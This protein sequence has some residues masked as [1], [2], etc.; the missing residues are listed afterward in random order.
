[1]MNCAV[2]C[3]WRE[4]QLTLKI[5]LCQKVTALFVFYFQLS[6]NASDADGQTGLHVAAA[7]GNLP[8]VNLLLKSG[9]SLTKDLSGQVSL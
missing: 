3:E 5:E 1:M 8:V 7:A 2:H 4:H 6:V 9:A